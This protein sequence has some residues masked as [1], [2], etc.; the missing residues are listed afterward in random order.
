MHLD[1]PSSLSRSAYRNPTQAS[2]MRASEVTYNAAI[3]AC[4]RGGEWQQVPC[5]LGA[6]DASPFAQGGCSD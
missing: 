3:T 2:R 4:E 6:G 1:Q 5:L